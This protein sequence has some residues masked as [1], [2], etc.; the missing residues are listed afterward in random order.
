MKME[1]AMNLSVTC[2]KR[3]CSRGLWKVRF[4]D[5]LS[6]LFLSLNLHLLQQMCMYQPWDLNTNCWPGGVVPV[7]TAADWIR[8]AVWLRWAGNANTGARWR[9]FKKLESRTCLRRK[10]GRTVTSHA[11][12]EERERCYRVSR[13]FFVC[14]AL[15]H[16][17]PPPPL[18]LLFT[19]W[20]PSQQLGQLREEPC[21]IWVSNGHATR[22]GLH[23]HHSTLIRFTKNM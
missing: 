13:I 11:V 6:F 17:S 10:K 2:W 23:S 20:Y 19:V 3:F 22:I 15:L 16:S 1:V 12:V 5:P 4:D 7:R 9:Q 18:L 21:A 8:K 14:D